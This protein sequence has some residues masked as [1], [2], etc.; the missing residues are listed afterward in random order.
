MIKLKSFSL[1]NRITSFFFGISIITI[2]VFTD[3]ISQYFESGLEDSAR[4]Q[5]LTESEAFSVAY[6]QNPNLELPSTFATKFS[7]D[8]LPVMEIRG[9]NVL[10][11]IE[12]VDGEFSII[13]TED[14]L[15]DGKEYDPMLV[16]YRQ[17][18]FDGKALYTL[19]SINF[20]SV[21]EHV[22]TIF[23][24]RVDAVLTIVMWY[25]GLTV[26][27]LWIYNYRVGKRTSE[28][29]E[30][31]ETVSTTFSEDT[32]NFKFDEY[33]RIAICLQN[34]LRKNAELIEREKKFLS[35]ASHELRTPIAIIRANTEIME[36]INLP[37]LADVPIA[38]IERAG[39]NMQQIT[40]TLLWLSRKTEGMPATA[41]ASVATLLDE[42]IEEQL[43]L[44]QG[45]EVEVIKEYSDHAERLLP[46]TPMSIVLGNL[47]RNAFQYTH[48]GWVRI[49]YCDD[50]VIIENEETSD[51]GEDYEVS[52]GF[53]LELTE[54][55]CS[56]LGW[57]L[58]VK[59]RKGG[60]TAQ[61]K[62]PN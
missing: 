3:L 55:V 40:E 51:S 57:S 15:V 48:C 7:L 61:L 2:V 21:R 11:N 5:V 30:W 25:L 45:E 18:M 13:F 33:N 46:V 26:L 12:I 8:A 59:N 6:K 36:K 35:H 37:E 10:K 53:G 16:L 4:L 60:V 62:L 23:D 29:V 28:L 20:D 27:V 43:Y 9:Q 52:F 19:T 42:I 22:D 49:R 54:K 31:A 17:K 56:K 38:R 39:S 50:A 32:P 44:L 14:I 24:S 58:T 47:I 41:Q 34:A 1:K